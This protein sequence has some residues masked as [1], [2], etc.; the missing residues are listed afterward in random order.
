[1]GLETGTYIDD[2]VITNPIGAADFVSVGDD[3]LRFVKKTLKNSFP[4]QTFPVGLVIDTGEA[5]AYA[6]A[7]DPAPSSLINGTEVTFLVVNTNT[8]ASTFDLNE[9]GAK[10][11]TLGNTDPLEG[12]ELRVGSFATLKYDLDLTVWQLLTVSGNYGPLLET[13]EL[14]SVVAGDISYSF[15]TTKTGWLR[16]YG[17]TLGSDSSGATE[18]NADYEILYTVFWENCADAEC[19]VSSG[20]GEDAAADFAA[21]KTL[22]MPDGRG[23]S[24]IAADNLGGSSA[25]VNTNPYADALGA[26][27]GE[28]THTQTEPELHAHTHGLQVENYTAGATSAVKDG[29]PT[30]T[31]TGTTGSSSAFNVVSPV[32]TM[33]M[34]VKI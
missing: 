14:S 28:Q 27:G 26:V 13:L 11:I 33:N 25:D 22:T 9:L 24:A 15:V 30:D 31:P 17:Q 29:N 16:L 8:T 7:M 2:L 12:G 18:A 20:R 10:A 19:P 34:F 6:G 23:R 1:M 3:H 5:N 4:S 32:L 21:D